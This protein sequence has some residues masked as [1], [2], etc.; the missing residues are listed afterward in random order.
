[1][2]KQLINVYY[3]DDTK[4]AACVTANESNISCFVRFM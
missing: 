1:V 4:V 2:I 3:S